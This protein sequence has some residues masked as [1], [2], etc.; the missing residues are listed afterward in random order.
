MNRISI[1]FDDLKIGKPLPYPLW[2]EAGFL[3]AERGF[4]IE[5]EKELQV[6]IGQR[7]KLLVDIADF[8]RAQRAFVKKLHDMVQD[9]RQIRQ[10][11]ETRLADMKVEPERELEVS[12]D[13]DWLDLQE[14]AHTL[15]RVS[16]PQAFA[17][18]LDRLQRQLAHHTTVNPDGTL[19][20][21]FNL[22]SKEFDRYSATHAMLVSVMCGLTARDV[23]K[24]PD[25]QQDVVCRAA[26]TMN[27]SMSLL[28]DRLAQQKEPLTVAQRESIRLH[29]ERSAQLLQR[30]GVDDQDMLDAVRHHHAR[31]SGP[32]APRS[33]GQRMARLIQRADIFAAAIAPRASRSAAPTQAAMKAAYFDERQQVDEA[34]AAMIKAVGVY[35]PGTYVRL[36]SEETAI[37]VRRGVNT[38]APRVA[39]VLTRGG[40]PNSELTLRD[41]SLPDWKVTGSIPRQGLKVNV[42]LARLLPLTRQSLSRFAA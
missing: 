39:V 16:N 34:G 29:P 26:L 27:I 28:Q 2:D 5:N 35:P 41:T 24:W 17:L 1:P 9:N 25:D 12:T 40:L 31:T 38:S 30:L 32:L 10:I 7:S 23:L 20:S 36:A 22:S 3:V 15:V 8:E 14:Q 4:V 19:L 21:L 13:A 37:V 6:M 11:A 42:G 33:V 18:R